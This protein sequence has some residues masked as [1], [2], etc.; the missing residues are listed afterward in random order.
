MPVRERP[1]SNGN[2]NVKLGEDSPESVTSGFQEVIMPE[3]TAEA[4]EYRNGNSKTNRPIK[5]NGGYEVGNVILKRGLIGSDNLWSWFQRVRDGEQD[6][7][8]RTVIIELLTEDREEVAV[9]WKL[10]NARPVKYRFS[11]LQANGDE[12]AL[13]IVELACEDIEME[14]A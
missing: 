5:V 6:E 11:D 9:S 10:I 14:F 1:F 7:P 4:I 3:I 12:I 2:F 13:E 8:L